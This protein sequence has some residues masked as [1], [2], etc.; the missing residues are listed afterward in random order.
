MRKKIIGWRTPQSFLKK[1]LCAFAFLAFLT[2]LSGQTP[3]GTPG[4]RKE[5]ETLVSLL[6]NNSFR[7]AEK[8]A[9]TIMARRPESPEIRAVCGLALLKMGRIAESEGIFTEILSRSP[10]NPDAHLGLGRI[11]RIRNDAEGAIR[12]L[13][14]AVGSE[15]F[16][17]EALR[18]LWRAA[19]EV[20]RASDLQEI[21]RLAE[22]RFQREKRP[23]PSWI[24]NGLSQLGGPAGEDLY[25]MEGAFEHLS[26]PLIRDE[27][28]RIR[29]I[30][31]RLNGRNEYPFDID[32]ASPD[33]I[34]VSPLLAL[35][36]GL[37]E[38]GSS[39]AVG[40]GTMAARVRFS[41]LDRID[42]DGVAF[43][44]VP[45]MVSDL[46]TF[47]GQKKG[48]IGTGFLKRFNC[49]IDVKREVM[50]LFRLDRPDLL[51]VNIDPAAIAVE[52]PLYIFDATTVEAVIEGGTAGLFI[53]D[54]AAGTNLIDSEFFAEHLKA[55]IDPSLIKTGNIVG[56]QGVQRVNF[57]DGLSIRLGPLAFDG[58]RLCE[59][60]M[61]ALNE[62]TGRYAAGLVGNPLLWPY[63]VHFDFHG[64]R[65][66]L[67]KHPE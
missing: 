43:R 60:S 40:V 29:M 14:P 32:S 13:R 9:D 59:F 12:H 47:R 34:T 21:H 56:S 25:R 4:T 22:A 10:D 28:S 66:I 35:E 7:D 55:A 16:F 5:A 19:R 8:A 53:L 44:N 31:L 52:V 20:G 51:K 67:E 41:A 39:S 38:T 49:T 62:I 36:L 1:A 17:E 26:V 3:D 61:D 65:L 45:V 46:Q 63:R 50:D 54:S 6:R 48:L 11:G 33:F 58:Q 37:Q 2:L 42:L 23:L 27:G 30:V 15:F 18:Q 64:G 24:V 57:M